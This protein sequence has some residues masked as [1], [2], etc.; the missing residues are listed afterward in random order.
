MHV[1]TGVHKLDLWPLREKVDGVLRS[2][3]DAKREVPVEE[4]VSLE[5][6]RETAKETH[7]LCSTCH[8]E[9]LMEWTEETK[10]ESVSIDRRDSAL[11]HSKKNCWLAHRDCN[12]AK[13]GTFV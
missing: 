13:K 3:F 9:Y 12:H 11:G 7:Y 8:T 10:L 1:F 5:W 6:L 2:D 4:R